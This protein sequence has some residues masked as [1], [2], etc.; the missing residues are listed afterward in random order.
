M[1]FLRLLIVLLLTNIITAQAQVS[2]QFGIVANRTSDTTA[3]L[4]ID[5]NPKDSSLKIFS[6]KQATD[7]GFASTF[8]FKSPASAIV[9]NITVNGNTSSLNIDEGNSAEVLNGSNQ[10]VVDIAFTEKDVQ[11]IEGQFNILGKD[12]DNYPSGVEEIAV[13]LKTASD[14]ENAPAADKSEAAPPVE[15][16]SKSGWGLFFMCLGFG[17]GAVFTPCVFPLIPVTVSFFLKSGGTKKEGVKKAWMYALSIILIYTIPTLILTLIFGDKFLYTVSSHPVTN[18]FFFAIFIVF[19][20]SFFGGFELQLP[21]SWANKAD[22]NAGKGGLI[23]VFFMAL[24][25]VIVSFSCTGPIVAALLGETSGK[26]IKMGSVFGMLGFGIGLAFPFAIFALFPNMLKSLPKS[27]GW[28][29]SVKVF[30]GFIELG[31]AMKFLS[32]ADLAYHWGLLNRDVF[33]AIWI[34]LAAVLGIYLLGKFKMSHDSDLKYISIPRLFIALASFTFAVYMIPGLFGAPLTPLSGILPPPGTQKFNL[35]DLQYKIGAG[36]GHATN[37]G[38]GNVP[39]PQKYVEKFHAPFGLTAYFDVD[40]ALAAAKI[41]N[42]PILL[43]FTGWSCANCRKMENEV[44]SKPEVLK[45]LK[46]DFILVSF[47]VDDKT[48]LPVE[49]RYTNKNGEKI[50]TIGEKNLDYE[51]TNFG[52]NA[53]PL[54][55]FI[56]LDGKS[57]SDVQYGYDPDI[58]KFIDHL[59]TVKAKFHKK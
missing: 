28:L 56:D 10:I 30:F 49:E 19:A 14:V 9:R 36:G 17:F 58:Q 35:D 53:Q 45:R 7:N 1:R 26:G 5:I 38:A 15:K 8:E 27:G 2:V 51:V 52:I 29:N 32:N 42:K 3:Q 50:K 40:E 39:A 59:E 47:Y 48:P 33:L 13:P 37:T 12:G 34:V 31:L 20:I 4:I 16:D 41:A 55:K 46:E 24:T 44:W 11:Q 22:Q 21:S 43:D 25:L 18:L 57:L 23:G 6:P 54:Y